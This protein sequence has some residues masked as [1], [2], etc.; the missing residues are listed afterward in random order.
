MFNY[1]IKSA[2]AVDLAVILHVISTIDKSKFKPLLKSTDIRKMDQYYE[3]YVKKE[4]KNG[5]CKNRYIY[6]VKKDEYEL[7]DYHRSISNVMSPPASDYVF[8]YKDKISSRDLAALHTNKK[9]LFKIDIKDYFPSIDDEMIE[10]LY[11]H[12]FDKDPELSKMKNKE[13]AAKAI[14]MLCTRSDLRPIEEGGGGYRPILPIGISP[15]S[16]ISNSVLFDF[17]HKVVE[18]IGR[19]YTYSRYSDNIFISTRLKGGLSE[20]MRQDIIGMLESVEIAGK[21]PFKVNEKKTQYVPST[22]SQRVLGTVVNEKVNIPKSKAMKTRSALNHLYYDSLKLYEDITAESKTT[23]E[24]WKEYYRLHS[25][26]RKVFGNLAY[27][28]TINKD[29]YLKYSAAHHAIKISL[30]NSRNLLIR[31]AGEEK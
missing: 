10:E 29:K 14:A 21:R 30:E 9:Y 18:E 3:S 19:S 6:Y 5:V 26:G 22:R 17:D 24:A 7:I 23:E 13:D 11:L 28:Q 1:K 16:S 25:R 8:S 2:G 4:Y 31:T 15:A 27:F 12:W 20:Q